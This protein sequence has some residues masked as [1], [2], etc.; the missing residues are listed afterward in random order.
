[1]GTRVAVM[2]RGQHR[3]R[4]ARR[5]RCTTKPET[6]FVAEFIGT[7]P[8]N[9]LPAGLFER[10]DR[11]RRRAA[12]ASACSTPTAV[13][14]R[15]TVAGRATRPRDAGDLRC[16][17]VP[18]SSCVRVPRCRRRRSAPRSGSTPPRPTATASTRSHDTGSIERSRC[19][20][21]KWRDL[22]I[23]VGM[24]VPSASI[25][26]VFVVYPLVRAIW[27]GHL[28]CDATGR[29]AERAG[30]TSTS[31]SSAATS[32]STRLATRHGCAVMTVP[33][34][35]VLGVGLAVLA[36]KHIRGVGFFRTIFSSTVATSVAVAPGVVR[37]AAARSRRA[38]RSAPRDHP[39]VKSPGPAAGRAP[40]S[41]QWR[42]AASGPASGSRSSS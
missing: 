19:V 37:P 14:L 18:A 20:K 26:G 33:V 32:S 24:L 11:A 2:S 21:R 15:V 35:L 9:M 34:G 6:V 1:M 39:V 23:A 25:L 22:P 16:G 42:S 17:R 13:E 7:P 28:R 10:S 29:R 38:A 4:S 30:G 40:R 12:R 8:M 27:L 41:R 5:R 3:N 36:D 31:T